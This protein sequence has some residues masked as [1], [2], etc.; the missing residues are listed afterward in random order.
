MM[1]NYKTASDII[2][3]LAGGS[4][5]FDALSNYE[6]YEK[7]LVECPVTGVGHIHEFLKHNVE[8]QWVYYCCEPEKGFPNSFLAMPS[9]RIRILGFLLYKYDIKGFLHWGFNYYNARVSRYPVNPYL[10]TSGDRAYP[11]GDPFI[12]YPGRDGVYSSLRGEVLYEGIQDMAVCFA[13]EEYIGRKEVIALIDRAAG[14]DLRFDRYPGGKEFL[15]GLRA[16]MIRK[17]SE[18]AAK[19]SHRCDP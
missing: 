11:S 17:I 13:L 8:E 5:I 12:V 14:F 7:G 2:R 10:T 18:C 1:D 9:C 19:E 3:S 6:F 4:K 16:Q 15:E